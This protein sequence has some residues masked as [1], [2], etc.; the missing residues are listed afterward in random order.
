[1][2]RA[3]AVKM[4]LH[5]AT[6][7]QMVDTA[8]DMA[9]HS[10]TKPRELTKEEKKAMTCM[11]AKV[12]NMQFKSDLKEYARFLNDESYRVEVNDGWKKKCEVHHTGQ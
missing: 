2:T 6:P 12:L 11:M 4:G 5:K 9:T 1:M 10:E 3:M 8:I 7:E